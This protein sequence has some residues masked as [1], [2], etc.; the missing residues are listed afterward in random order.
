MSPHPT[1]TVG[2]QLKRWRH[3]VG[4]RAA[5]A[6]KALGV[7][8]QT[9][10]NWE[11]DASR[12]HISRA[13]AIEDL[14]GIQPGLVTAILSGAEPDGDAPDP[15]LVGEQNGVLLW[16]ARRPWR[17][18]EPGDILHEQYV[19]LEHD[20][21]V[22]AAIALDSDL[23]EEQK[24]VLSLTYRTFKGLPTEARPSPSSEPEGP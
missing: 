23:S 3:D 21:D 12:P 16:S 5:D 14:Y 24:R 11:V 18:E 17:P 2:R 20:T 9:V 1:W 19:E 15:E 4:L 13:R 8:Q 10:S 22:E 6:A 7:S